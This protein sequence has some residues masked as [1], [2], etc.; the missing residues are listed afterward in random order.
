MWREAA[1]VLLGAVAGVASG[2]VGIGG[3][4]VMVPVLVFF[5]GFSQHTAQGTTLAMMLPPIGLGAVTVYYRAG[6]VDLKTAGLLCLG[7]VLGG[8]LGARL[9]TGLGTTAL[10]RVFGVACIAVGIKMLVAR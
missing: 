3:G 9:A 6:L 8:V 2:L 7:F 4:I 5:F 10:E 1:L